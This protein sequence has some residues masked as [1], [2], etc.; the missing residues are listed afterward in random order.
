MRDNI[1]DLVICLAVLFGTA[2]IL[3]AIERSNRET[4]PVPFQST[5]DEAFENIFPSMGQD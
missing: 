3:A 5:V 2:I 4:T 1:R